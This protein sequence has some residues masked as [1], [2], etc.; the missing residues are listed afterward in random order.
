LCRRG[1][2]Y[3]LGYATLLLETSFE[4]NV[5]KQLSPEFPNVD[6]L[7]E[8]KGQRILADISSLNQEN[9]VGLVSD[10]DLTTKAQAWAARPA[11]Y[12]PSTT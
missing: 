2:P 4:Q 7:L 1:Y 6:K 8:L 12:S 9:S 3:H 11:R 10:A 5:D